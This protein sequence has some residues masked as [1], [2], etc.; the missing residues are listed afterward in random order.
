MYIQG[1]TVEVQNPTHRNVTGSSMTATLSVLSPS[2][3]LSPPACHY[4][5]TPRGNFRRVGKKR[6]YFKHIDFLKNCVR[7]KL[8]N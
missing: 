6:Y 5:F 3:I 1:D 4:A 7:L 2:S 8:R